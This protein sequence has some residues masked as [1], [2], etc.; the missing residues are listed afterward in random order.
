ML[1]DAGRSAADSFLT[2]HGRR[3]GPTLLLRSRRSAEECVSSG[4]FRCSA[5]QFGE[6]SGALADVGWLHAEGLY[7]RGGAE[8]AASLGSR[9]M[10]HFVQG[11]LCVFGI[12]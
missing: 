4:A 6:F 12:D 11:D 2:A 1:R 9:P 5:G 10:F 8:S 3:F 7:L